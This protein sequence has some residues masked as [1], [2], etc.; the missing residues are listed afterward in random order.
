[1]SEVTSGIPIPGF[2]AKLYRAGNPGI[3]TG[4]TPDSRLRTPSGNEVLSWV[5]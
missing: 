1:M 3:D 2:V 5:K 4:T